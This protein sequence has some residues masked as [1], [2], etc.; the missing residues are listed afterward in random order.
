MSELPNYEV[1][2]I[3]Y[4]TRAARR[5]E[6]FIGGD[7]HDGPMPLDYYVWAAI[8]PDRS[9]VIDTGFTAE[10][11]AKR[12]RDYLRCPIESLKLIGLEPTR[13]KDVI[14]THLHY[15]HVGSFDKLPAATFHLQES[16]LHY[17]VG[18][19]MRYKRLQHSYEVE[20]VVGIVRAN[21]AGRVNFYEGSAELSP[22]ITIH[23]APG[24]SAGLQFVRVHTK[25][26]WVVLASDVTHFYE[27]M[28]SSRPFTTAFHIGEMLEG[29]ER[30]LTLAPDEGHIIP[31]HDP[32]VMK[33]YPAP[34]PELEG[35]AV[36]LD[37]PPSGV[38]PRRA[39][40]SSHH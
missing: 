3:R 16:E 14:L 30:L 37:A 38:A 40:Y 5:S 8:G 36:R 29:F 19:Y 31:G 24:H 21:Y 20:D 28:A 6:N 25:R 7:P 22:G 34:I 23:P 17:A 33:L 10:I 18:R 9:Y 32:L 39:D 26:G 35:V 13:V 1:Y 2:A 4:A 12:K 15:D 27:N 11:A